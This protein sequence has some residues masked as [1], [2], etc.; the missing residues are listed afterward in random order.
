MG[1][2][3]SRN[4]V[5]VRLSSPKEAV[6]T[7]LEHLIDDLKIESVVIEPSDNFYWDMD[8]N[9]CTTSRMTSQN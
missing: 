2:P 4:A 9:F 8:K 7:I 3:T 5:Q 1:D 6:D